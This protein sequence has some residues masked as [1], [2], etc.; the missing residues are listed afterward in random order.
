MARTIIPAGRRAHV[1]AR[2]KRADRASSVNLRSAANLK[3]VRL[4][5]R[6]GA[7]LHHQIFLVMRDQIL[8]G[9]YGA[10][11]LLPTED[12]LTKLFGVSRITVRTALARLES[13]GLIRRR[14]G[15]GTFVKQGAPKPIRVG[16]REQRARLEQLSQA[17]TLKLL[18]M[19]CGTV[20]ADVQSWFHCK[21]D[22]QFT[23]VVRIRAAYCYIIITRI[24]ETLARGGTCGSD[25]TARKVAF[26][27][28]C[29]GIG[30]RLSGRPDSR[31]RSIT[32]PRHRRQ[33][34]PAFHRC[35]GRR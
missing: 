28:V 3:D 29:F 18:E 27:R 12:D 9:R 17:T 11:E 32:L 7:S 35:V 5:R 2:G 14:Q 15:V 25:R 6:L 24:A 22:A 20:P 8:S 4:S 16:I 19:D 1:S 30:G 31:R 23:R 26:H 10:A 21:P 33:G 13:S 34:E